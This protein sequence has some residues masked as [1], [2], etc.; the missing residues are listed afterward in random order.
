[1]EIVEDLR[2]Q[3]RKRARVKT[4]MIYSNPTEAEQASLKIKAN[5]LELRMEQIHDRLDSALKLNGKG[6]DA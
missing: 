3:V 1:M 5:E 2:N 6:N 4:D